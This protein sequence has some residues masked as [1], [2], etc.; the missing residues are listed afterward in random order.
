MKKGIGFLMSI[1]L[2]VFIIPLN[3]NADADTKNEFAPEV[4]YYEILNEQR[5][6]YAEGYRFLDLDGDGI[7]ELLISEK[8]HILAIYTA[9]IQ[10]NKPVIVFSQAAGGIYHYEISGN[11]IVCYNPSPNM[12][13]QAYGHI[14]YRISEG[15]LIP[16]VG[17]IYNSYPTI[18]YYKTD[19]KELLNYPPNFDFS[20]WD[21]I[22]SEEFHNYYNNNFVC[23]NITIE[24]FNPYMESFAI[25]DAEIEFHEKNQETTLAVSGR[26][27]YDELIQ[28]YKELFASPNLIP[29]LKVTQGIN[30]LNTDNYS[31]L[32]REY[33][34]TNPC[35]VLRDLNND[36]T[37]EFITGCQE[38][39]GTFTLFDIYTIKNNKIV[40]IAA[41]GW[42]DRFSLSHNNEIIESGSS[43]AANGIAIDYK[44]ENGRLK[45][46]KVLS[47]ENGKNYYYFNFGTA[48]E[49]KEEITREE[50]LEKDKLVYAPD[51]NQNFILFK[52]WY[53]GMNL[54]ES[55]IGDVNCDNIID[56]RDATSVLT[57]YAV[58]STGSKYNNSDFHVEYAD[59]IEDE[60][61]DARDA[62]AILTYYAK[63]STVN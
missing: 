21:E 17:Y 28:R 43:G 4:F 14:Y 51:A 40:H 62:T 30:C 39:D 5:P 3:A 36:G 59:Y 57:Y 34:Y 49:N 12:H 29:T 20:K 11:G 61:I 60:I 41:S 48:T 8:Y 55:L 22:T 9:D 63:A 42:R 45:P 15:T 52:D 53:A 44:I 13:G 37:Y 18:G 25:Y 32:L 23:N 2:S 50:Y 56:G 19:Y 38:N 16:I 54:S 7:E 46:I 47:I 1:I 27:G 10:A 35:F 31:F 26:Y 33:T 6:E 58:T 24:P